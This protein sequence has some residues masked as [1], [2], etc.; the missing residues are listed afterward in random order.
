MTTLTYTVRVSCLASDAG[1]AVPHLTCICTCACALGSLTTRNR[2]SLVS[3]TFKFKGAI[4]APYLK[5][6]GLLPDVLD[7]PNWTKKH[8]DKVAAAVAAWCR[9]KNASMVTHWFQPLG[10]AG[11]RRGQTGQVHK[12]MFRFGRRTHA[13]PFPC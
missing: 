13:T 5:A 4:A 8:A 7:D 2:V 10:S 11:V 12:A 3:G 1:L 9:S 6:Q